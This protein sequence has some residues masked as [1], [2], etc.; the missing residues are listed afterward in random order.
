MKK[1]TKN[2]D[3]FQIGSFTSNQYNGNKVAFVWA[4]T[5]SNAKMVYQIGAVNAADH[6]SL[7]WFHKYPRANVLSFKSSNIKDKNKAAARAIV[8]FLKYKCYC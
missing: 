3:D 5:P 8:E 4:N 2:K 6:S 7:T 1:K